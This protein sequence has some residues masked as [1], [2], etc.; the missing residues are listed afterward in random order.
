[1]R[2]FTLKPLKFLIDFLMFL[3]FYRVGIDE[4]VEIP[5][6]VCTIAFPTFR[7]SFHIYEPRYRLM[8]R[9]CMESGSKKFGVCIPQDDGSYSNIGKHIFR[10]P[11]YEV[12]QCQKISRKS[13]VIR[14]IVKFCVFL[15]EF[16]FANQQD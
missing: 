6:F 8:I 15:M 11:F 5:I 2:L 4:E 12:L 1:M 10:F 14:P 3:F 13:S 7:C 16:N 9:E